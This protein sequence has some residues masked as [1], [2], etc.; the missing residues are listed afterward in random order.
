MQSATLEG[1]TIAID[2]FKIRAQNSLKNNLNQAKIERHLAY[3]DDKIDQ[4]ETELDQ[5]D[6]E[7]QQHELREKFR[8]QQA[9]RS[10]YKAAEKKLQE[11]GQEQISL[12]DPDSRAVVLHRNIVNVGYNIQASVDSK[13]KLLVE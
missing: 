11:T 8:Q 9:R 13:N 3:I 7:D 6:R 1:K 4:Y 5:A 12:T 2:S 10:S